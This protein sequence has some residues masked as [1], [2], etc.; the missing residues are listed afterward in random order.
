M[1]HHYKNVMRK[2]AKLITLVIIFVVLG[3]LATMLANQC[4]FI[5]CEPTTE[6]P[7]IVNHPEGEL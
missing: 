5:G 1:L 6:N 7:A 2:D 3:I 4:D